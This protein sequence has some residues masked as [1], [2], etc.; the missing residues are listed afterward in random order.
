MGQCATA[1]WLVLV[2]FFAGILA[3]NHDFKQPPMLLTV[4]QWIRNRPIS[5]E[6]KYFKRSA[7]LRLKSAMM[8][9]F[10]YLIR[11]TFF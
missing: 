2:V 8:A 1:W 7:D 6:H 11:R 4:R 3:C 5:L 10:I 9:M